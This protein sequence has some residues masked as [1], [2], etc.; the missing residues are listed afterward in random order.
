MNQ[1]AALGPQMVNDQKAQ[2]TGT[3]SRNDNTTS[4]PQATSQA[5]GPTTPQ[6]SSPASQNSSSTP[7]DSSPATEDS[8]STPTP[9]DSTTYDPEE[10]EKEEY[11][12]Y[13]T[14]CNVV[15]DYKIHRHEGI[16]PHHGGKRNPDLFD[17]EF[18][19]NKSMVTYAQRFVLRYTSEE[20]S[21]SNGI[22]T[23]TQPTVAKFQVFRYDDTAKGVLKIENLR[24][25]VYY[26]R[27]CA[28]TVKFQ[29]NLLKS[30]PNGAKLH[31]IALGTNRYKRHMETKSVDNRVLTFQCNVNDMLIDVLQKPD[32]SFYATPNPVGPDR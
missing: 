13:E 5:S 2:S 21:Q 14:H 17:V 8:S 9:Q 3:P 7:Q 16:A 22:S 25:G 24:K 4:P 10:K 6:D 18:T 32:G 26:F 1:F 31:K 11:M 15:Q 20:D 19:V 29:P 12:M 30:W 28:T 27:V 23:D